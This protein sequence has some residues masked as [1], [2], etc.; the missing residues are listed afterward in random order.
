MHVRKSKSQ[1]K[2]STALVF[3]LFSFLIVAPAVIVVIALFPYA[4]FALGRPAGVTGPTGAA[5]PPATFCT[6]L[7]VSPR[8]ICLKQSVM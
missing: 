8:D 3:Q 7:R 6:L 4:L 2:K 1:W 5:D